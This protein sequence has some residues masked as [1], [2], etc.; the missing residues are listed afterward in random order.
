MSVSIGDG[1]TSIGSYAFQKCVALETVQV[2]SKVENIGYRAFYNCTSLKDINWSNNIRSYGADVFRGCSSL[3]SAELSSGLESMGSGVFQDCKKLTSLIVNEGCTVI[4][5]SAFEGCL[6]LFSVS[7]PQSVTTLGSSA[8]SGCKALKVANVGNGVRKFSSYTFQNCEGLETVRIGSKVTEIGYR[9]F[10]NCKSLISFSCY[11]I[12]PPSLNKDAFSSYTST[13][14][15]PASAVETY[16]TAEVWE[17][18]GNHIEALPSYV[19]LA[20]KQSNGGVVRARL[21]VGESYNFIIQ[22]TEGVKL[23]SVLYNGTDVT[24]QLVENTYTTPAITEDSDLVVNFDSDSGQGRKG[25]MNGDNK[26]DAAD[27]VLLVDEVMK[28]EKK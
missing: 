16:R 19:N 25:D 14:C 13:V 21:N 27:V 10:Y 18:F 12:E 11:S 24:K 26:L 23:L 8:F 4:G 28:E 20:I 7:I 17:K 9:A 15:V 22:P 2:G 1:V 6:T 3:E 5:E